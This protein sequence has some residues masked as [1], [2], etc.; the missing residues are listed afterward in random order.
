MGSMIGM[1][2]SSSS[3]TSSGSE[4]SSESDDSDEERTQKLVA[5]QQEVDMYII[6]FFI[7]DTDAILF[8][9]VSKMNLIYSLKLCKNK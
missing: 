2:G 9:N 4:S 3:A 5:L 8:I 6:Y 1:K 7:F